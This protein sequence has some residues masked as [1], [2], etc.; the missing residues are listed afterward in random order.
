MRSAHYIPFFLPLAL[1]WP[2]SKHRGYSTSTSQLHESLQDEWY[3][4]YTKDNQS[5]VTTLPAKKVQV[6]SDSTG[7]YSCV[8]PKAEDFPGK[9]EWLTFDQLWE[10]NE[11]V[12]ETAN[13]GNSYN[14]DLQA[15]IKD[16]AAD[17][18]VDARLILA[19]IMQEVG[20]HL[21]LLEVTI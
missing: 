18:K 21:S 9:D 10:I 12:I 20:S 16:V 1:A 13:G 5:E 3:T 15:A 2:F 14:D 11:P 17:S 6:P 19:I 7:V 8:G 4:K